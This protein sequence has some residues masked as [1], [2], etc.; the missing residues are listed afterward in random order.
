MTLSI[1]WGPMPNFGYYVA[2]TVDGKLN[3]VVRFP[4]THN[5]VVRTIKR[6]EKKYGDSI[7]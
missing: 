7:S 1:E 4:L 5:G 3:H 2:A 6:L